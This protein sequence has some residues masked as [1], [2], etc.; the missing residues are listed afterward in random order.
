[1]ILFC[2]RYYKQN[3]TH[4][5]QALVKKSDRKLHRLLGVYKAL[6]WAPKEQAL[7]AK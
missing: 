3:L 4:N 1:M 2:F 5:S 6:G 7:A